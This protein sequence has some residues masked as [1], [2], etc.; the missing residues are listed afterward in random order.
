MVAE[1][2]GESLL[3]GLMLFGGFVLVFRCPRTF[4]TI[5]LRSVCLLL[6]NIAY[7]A[8]P[9]YNTGS[10]F[11]LRSCCSPSALPRQLFELS[12]S[13]SVLCGGSDCCIF[14]FCQCAGGNSGQTCK[15]TLDP[16]SDKHRLFALTASLMFTK[17]VFYPDVYSGSPKLH[18]IISSRPQLSELLCISGS[19][20]SHFAASNPQ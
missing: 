9:T 8:L 11:R 2:I 15:N 7:N 10:P 3:R 16:R 1:A 12:Y 19:A 4:P 5:V 13:H 20:G 17:N 18:G 6:P 14:R